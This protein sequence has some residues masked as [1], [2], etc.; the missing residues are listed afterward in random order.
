MRIHDII[1]GLPRSG[2]TLVA[3]IVA[4][5]R[6]DA[7]LLGEPV[8]LLEL[9]A[10]RAFQRGEFAAALHGYCEERL[11]EAARKGSYLDRRLP[12]LGVPDNYYG[13]AAPMVD[14]RTVPTPP[15]G[16]SSVICKHN[17]LFIPLAREI[18]A[19]PGLRLLRVVRHPAGALPSWRRHPIPVREGRSPDAES[20]SPELARRLDATADCSERQA[21]LYGFLLREIAAPGV[22]RESGLLRYE[23]LVQGAP[24]PPPHEHCPTRPFLK[25]S[26]ANTPQLSPQE[27][28]SFLQTLQRLDPSAAALLETIFKPAGESGR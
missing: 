20:W 19:H 28:S 14:F 1:T 10:S 5:A 17:A 27:T 3:R 18:A 15:G 11:A 2:T 7:M 25:A 4:A 16:C 8:D 6:P 12:N 13:A 21:I 9:R 23:D 26:A 24:L 22:S